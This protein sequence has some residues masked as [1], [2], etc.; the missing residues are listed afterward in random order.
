MSKKNNTV[1]YSD[2]SETGDE[3]E[4]DD[5]VGLVLKE[6]SEQPSS[7]SRR[8]Y[9]VSG[10]ARGLGR[11]LPSCCNPSLL[12][13]NEKI[14]LVVGVFALVAIIAIFVAVGVIAG[15]SASLG[16]GNVKTGSNGTNSSGPGDH[17]N[18][19][20]GSNGTTNTTT[21]QSTAPWSDIR[22]Q[23]AVVP[24]SYDISL[25]L[26]MDDFTV[27][28]SVDIQ[29][30][31]TEGGV[32]YVALHAKD[33]SVA[34]DGHRLL[35]ADGQEVEHSPIWYPENDF[36]VFNLSRHLD[37]GPLSI[38]MRFNY[39]LRE[40]LNGFYQSSYVDAANRT[41]YLATTQF[42]ATDA[43]KAFPCFDEPS[44]KAN[45][46]LHMTHQPRYRAWFNMPPVSNSTDPSTGMVTT[47]FM[48][49]HRMSTYLVAFIVSD[50][51]CVGN[52]IVSISGEEIEVS[53]VGWK[54]G[55]NEL[56]L[57]DPAAPWANRKWPG[58]K[59][60]YFQRLVCNSS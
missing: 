25:A 4:D 45:F 53:L 8:K 33:M 30:M 39:T 57:S 60:G 37:P 59:G 13:R 58:W 50:F 27:T 51:E 55:Y 1:A 9:T 32:D 42:E 28:G 3:P 41:Q 14:C 20:N 29:C 15:Q 38:H 18:P 6:D 31:V 10:P 22:L 24:E 36:F 52:T 48:T 19:G 44:L 21:G 12:T 49:S 40:V 17:S 56:S 43:R 5:G 23:S 46:T 7:R 11:R 35:R 54:L 47:H 26:N 16:S 2:L 34:E